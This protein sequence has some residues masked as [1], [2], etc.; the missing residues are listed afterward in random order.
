MNH[1][2]PPYSQKKYDFALYLAV[3]YARTKTQRR[4]AT[5]MYGKMIQTATYAYG[6]ND[7][8]F[9]STIKDFEAKHATVLSPEKK[10][11]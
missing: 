2:I 6:K 9:A 3:T 5:D 1:E 11:E 7:E 4:V 8:L 10:K